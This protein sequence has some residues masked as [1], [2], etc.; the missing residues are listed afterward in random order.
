M[1]ASSV[2]P[3][4][5]AA[6]SEPTTDAPLHTL[7]ELHDALAAAPVSG[8]VR[9]ERGAVGYTDEASARADDAP[10]WS[11]R[12][13]EMRRR[14]QAGEVSWLESAGRY[15]VVADKGD[16]VEVEGPLGSKAQGRC[17]AGDFQRAVARL[18]VRVHAFVR[19][20]DL[21]P[22]LTRPVAIEYP[23]GTAF[24]AAPG[25]LVDASDLA[26]AHGGEIR[27]V[28]MPLADLPAA[29]PFEAVGYGHPLDDKT[30]LDALTPEGRPRK[31]C[32]AGFDACWIPDEPDPKFDWGG[33][34]AVLTGKILTRPAFGR[35]FAP[36]MPDEEGDDARITFQS[37]C[38]DVRV[39][40]PTSAIVPHREYGPWVR[41]EGLPGIGCGGGGC[42][43]PLIHLNDGATAYWMDGRVAGHVERDPE[44][45]DPPVM[46]LFGK[47][48]RTCSADFGFR[49]PL[50]FAPNDFYEER[51]KLGRDTSAPPRPDG[52]EG[53]EKPDD[54]LPESLID[55]LDGL[56]RGRHSSG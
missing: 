37:G 26:S 21:L 5:S 23:D 27:F 1:A 32:S 3:S 6:P 41:V 38:V 20:R 8:F 10:G 43:P 18:P 47:D 15:K 36:L 28:E 45:P 49:E 13:A 25:M 30:D 2:A 14:E 22:L 40:V 29:V 16:V 56:L 39:H 55:R 33:A 51:R 34:K 52:D 42:A 31:A 24:A 46:K 53:R 7:A 11:E 48:G 4:A 50:C 9:L 19:R 35:A 12:A 54:A 17:R 44:N